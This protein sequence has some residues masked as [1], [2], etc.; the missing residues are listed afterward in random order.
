MIIFRITFE[1]KMSDLH[2]QQHIFKK[3]KENLKLLLYLKLE[4][5]SFSKDHYQSNQCYRQ[6]FG[7]LNLNLFFISLN[8]KNNF[9]KHEVVYF[10][11]KNSYLMFLVSLILFNEQRIFSF[12]LTANGGE[13][14]RTTANRRERPRT[15]ANGRERLRTAANGC[16]RLRTAAN[17]GERSRTVANACERLRKLANGY[18]PF[19]LCSYEWPEQYI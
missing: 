5:Q 13:R 7:I 8:L 1:R 17:G 12:K 10:I 2:L 16:E 9:L 4:N 6:S 3:F 18:L 19:V 11:N 15:A 14:W